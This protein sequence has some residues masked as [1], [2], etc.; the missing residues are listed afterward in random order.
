VIIGELSLQVIAG[1]EW[2]QRKAPANFGQNAFLLGPGKMSTSALTD[3][4][5]EL[6]ECG[7]EF[8]FNGTM[9]GC[10]IIVSADPPS[11]RKVCTECEEMDA[12]DH[13]LH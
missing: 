3:F 2:T 13:D 9:V 6:A 11:W 8:R 4:V 1:E 12:P 5:A 10:I 7:A